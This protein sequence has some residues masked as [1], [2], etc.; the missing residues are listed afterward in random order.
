MHGAFDGFR[1]AAAAAAQTWGI[2]LGVPIWIAT[3]M[4]GDDLLV[5]ET[6]GSAPPS[7]T[8]G[9]VLP[10]STSLR[11]KMRT[12]HDR[13]IFSVPAQETDP[14]LT[15][16]R[17]PMCHLGVPLRTASGDVVGMLCGLSERPMTATPEDVEP[18]LGLT[19]QL[20]ATVLATEV[21]GAD[22]RRA[23]ED[24]R[25]QS[26]TDS[27]TGLA[28]RRAWDRFLEREEARCARYEHPAAVV[29][30][31]LDGLKRVNDEQGHAAGDT[32]LRTAASG[33][34]A[35]IRAVDFA[36]RLGGDEFG[37]IA[38]EVERPG[39]EVVR[40][41]VEAALR[42]RGVRAAVGVAARHASVGLS[43]AWREADMDMYQ[44][45]PN[46]RRAPAGARPGES[47]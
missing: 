8:K 40:Q 42:D 14:G 6:Y 15:P 27:L 20:L 9:S 39:V 35:A 28:N 7:V 22:A 33:L 25:A 38:V 13:V 5:L 26:L 2:R 11:D 36:A 12:E 4:D 10:W 17:D 41:R 44:R 43:G 19:G 47:F 32:L 1:A 34:V 31:D 30:V 29:V 23:A 24:L 21:R 37:V 46:A 18:M 3:L 16:G 45:K